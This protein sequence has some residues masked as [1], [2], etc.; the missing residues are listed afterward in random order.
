LFEIRNTKYL[1]TADIVHLFSSK[2]TEKE[3]KVS[4]I[5][6]DDLVICKVIEK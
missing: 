6:T 4:S 2:P 3:I 1:K 5:M